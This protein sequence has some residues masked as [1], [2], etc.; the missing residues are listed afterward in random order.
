[1]EVSAAIDMSVVRVDWK[2]ESGYTGQ[3]RVKSAGFIGLIRTRSKCIVQLLRVEF[4][5][6]GE[7]ALSL[8]YADTASWALG[9][10]LIRCSCRP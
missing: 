8:A 9:S 4:E 10:Y 3:H 5:S 2:V 6:S 7:S 1:V